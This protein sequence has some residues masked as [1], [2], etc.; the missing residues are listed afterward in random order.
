VWG[1][2]R[3]VAALA[4]H[5]GGPTRIQAETSNIPESKGN[6]SLKVGGISFQVSEFGAGARSVFRFWGGT[7]ASSIEKIDAFL[8]GRAK[9]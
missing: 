2:G 6:F 3:R 9:H 1:D 4:I 7:R 8:L 5:I